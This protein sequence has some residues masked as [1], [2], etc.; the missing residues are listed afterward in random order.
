M[1]GRSESDRG[2]DEVSSATFGDE[3]KTELKLDDDECQGHTAPK[4]RSSGGD[5][6]IGDT[7]SSHLTNP[8]MES[9][10]F[11]TCSNVLNN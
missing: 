5:L 1:E 3:E 7:T 10:T 2:E 8:G 11:R 6:L 9:N 4:K